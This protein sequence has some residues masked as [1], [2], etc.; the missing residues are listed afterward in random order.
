MKFNV[1]EDAKK[2]LTDYCDKHNSKDLKGLLASEEHGEPIAKI[3]YK[4]IPKIGRAVFSE[5]KFIVFFKQ[6]KDLILSHIV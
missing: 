2:E 4:Y 5:E 6:H 3:I 1:S